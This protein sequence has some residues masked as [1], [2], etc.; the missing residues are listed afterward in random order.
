MQQDFDANIWGFRIGPYI[1]YLPSEKWMLHLSGG[2]ALGLIDA[3]A[4]WKETLSVTGGD[5][6]FLKGGGDD[7]SLLAGF[8][9]GVSA[10]Y[11]FNDKATMGIVTANSR[12][13]GRWISEPD[14]GI[15]EAMNKG[16]VLSRGEWLLF[17]QSDDFLAEDDVLA[18]AAVHLTP[19]LDICGF[20]VLYGNDSSIA[21]MRPRGANYWLNFKTGLN[22]QGT[23]IRRSLFDRIGLYDTSFKIAMDYEF[24]LRAYR[25]DAH[26]K[27][28]SEPVLAV[29]RDTGISSQL[30]WPN[31]ERRF[32]EEKRV[33]RKFETRR[34]SLLYD[35]WW[36]LYP[37][38]RKLRAKLPARL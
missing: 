26:F 16:I 23:F 25:A 19:D 13:G 3:N 36:A 9:I 35:A 22:H 34:L 17:L 6:T 37:R 11:K 32:A 33:H 4:S 7:L 38:F 27:C 1:E 2:L 15:A 12:A 30:D 21:T 10:Q 29:M 18:K 5:T 14:E 20:P 8:Y 28:H 31:L 24:F